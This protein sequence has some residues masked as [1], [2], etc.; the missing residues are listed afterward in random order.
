TSKAL[1]ALFEFRR[2]VNSAMD[3]G[4]FGA[5]DRRDVIEL[6]ERIDSVLGVLGEE[7]QDILEPEIE[8]M[9]ELRNQSRRDRDFKK[10]DEIRTELL[11]R[12]I[13]LEDTPQGTKWKRK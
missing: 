9:I 1:A 11:A 13:I 3:S 5:D 7:K 12:G 4:A 2:D 8:A 6:L 10:A